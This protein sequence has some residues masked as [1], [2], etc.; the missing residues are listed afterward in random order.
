MGRLVEGKW[1]DE[2]YD[3]EAHE[4]E[5]VRE[6]AAWRNWVTP[7]G[8]PGPTGEGGFAAAAGRYHLYV[9]LACPWAHRTL[10]LRK[11]KGLEEVIDYSVVHPHMLADGWTFA[12][13]FP[14]ATGDRLFGAKF[15]REVYTRARPDC[16]GRV[17]VPVLWDRERD[18]IVS[19]ESADI[20][21]MLDAAFDALTESDACFSPA[22]LFD[23]ID[24][25]NAEV[26]DNVNNGVYRAG[27]ATSQK[28]YEKAFDDLFATL[29]RL[30][31]RLSRSRFLVGGVITEADWRLF[32]TLVRFDAVY[33]GHFK[34][35]A[36]R[37]RDY[38]A[39]SA[40]LR[41]LYQYPGVAGTV[42]LDH[43]KQHYYYSHDMINP[44]RIV[45]KGPTLDLAAPHDRDALGPLQ[46]RRSS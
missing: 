38:P 32:T 25:V 20:V 24:T 1:V 34:C 3:T 21:R 43:I 16:S 46:V 14:G 19:N 44:S 39:L 33:V 36:R 7:D 11:L 12:E 10:I 40:Y 18:T 30:D 31:E 23:E 41:D 29:D 35:N 6:D 26:Y 37:I 45:P 4:G 28:A 27:F 8:R 2:W 9:S 17:T 15:M 13:D 22:D 5:F 42:D